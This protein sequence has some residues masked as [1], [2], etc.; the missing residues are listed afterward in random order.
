M[1]KIG[2]RNTGLKWDEIRQHGQD[3]TVRVKTGTDSALRA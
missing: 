1:F 2:G 3:K